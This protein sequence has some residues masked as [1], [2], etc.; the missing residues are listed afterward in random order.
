[1]IA[2]SESPQRPGQV[3]ASNV[4]ATLARCVENRAPVTILIDTGQGKLTGRFHHLE[5]TTFTVRLPHAAPQLDEQQPL[6]VTFVV[7]GRWVA[8]L[9]RVLGCRKAPQGWF[10][11]LAMPRAMQTEMRLYPRIR[12]GRGSDLRA[13]LSVNEEQFDPLVEDLSLGGTLITFPDNCPAWKRG[14]LVRVRLVLG[15][16]QLTLIATVVR[17]AKGGYGLTFNRF[18]ASADQQQQKLQQILTEL[19]RQNA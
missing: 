10:V 2:A 3:R 11:N 15:L 4:P 7:D 18:R 16:A 1:M 8:V 12:V 6:A 14:T 13:S 19:E 17:E 5:D 9:S